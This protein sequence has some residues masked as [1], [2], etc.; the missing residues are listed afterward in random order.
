MLRNPAMKG[1][2]WAAI[3]DVT[4]HPNLDPEHV[5]LTTKMIID[6]PIGPSDKPREEVEEI[7]VGAAREKEIEAKLVNISTDWAVQDLALAHFKTRGE[8]L[9]KGD[10]TAEIQTLL[11]DSLVTLNS[12]A[13]NRFNK[14]FKAQIN[15]WMAALSTVNEVMD[16]WTK[17][18]N[19]WVYLEAVF[20]GGD[21]AKQMPQEA[22]R[23]TNVDKSWVKLMERAR[24]NPG[25]VSCCTVD[26]TLQELLPRM[27]DQLEM[28]QRSLSGYLEGKRRLFPR[29][30]F[31]SDPVLLEILGQ[32]STPEAIQQHLLTIFDSMDHLKFNESVSRVLVAYS[33]DGED[34]PLQPTVECMGP[35]EIWLGQL[36]LCARE[37]LLDRI[38]TSHLMLSDP[39][40]DLLRFF[41]ENP[42]QLGILGIQMIWTHDATEALDEA[43]ENPKLMVDTNRNFLLLLELLISQTTRPLSKY[44]RTKYETLITIHLHQKDIFDSLIKQGIKSSK[45]FEWLKQTRVYYSEDLNVCVVS[46]TN[47]DFVYQNEFLGCTERLVITPLTDRCYI[48]LAQALNMSFGGAPAGPAGTGKTETT[49]DM[50]RCLGQY[51][52]VFNCSD[53]MDFRGLGR[54]FKGLAQSGAWGCFDEFNRIELPVLSVAAQ[55]IAIVLFA[56]RDGQDEFVFSDG[57][58]VPLNA[59]FG[60]FITMNPGYAGRQELPENLKINFR[61]VAMMV[62]DRQI[63]IRVKMASCGF[64][65]NAPLAKKF[66][67]LYGLCE[68]QLSKQVHYDFGLRNILSVLRTFGAVRRSNP[69]EPENRIVMRVLRDMNLSKLVDQDEPLFMSILKDLF[70]GVV[71]TSDVR[72]PELMGSLE[73][74]AAEMDLIPHKPWMLKVLQLYETQNVRHGMMTLGPSGSG[75]SKC[76]NLLLRALTEI[77]EPHKEMRMNPKAITAPQMFGRLDA[78]TN[79]WTDGIFSTLWR[80]TV[81][82]KKGEHCWLILDGPVD[83]IWIE[84]LNSVLDDN[85]TLTLANGDRIPMSPR[86]K[87][88]FEVDNVDNASPATISRN[89]I[90]YISSGALNWE[91]IFKTWVKKRSQ[92]DADKLLNLANHIFPKLI[93]FVMQ[94][95]TVDMRFLEAFYVTQFGRVFDAVVPSLDALPPAGL[96]RIFLFSL[97]WSF[98]ALLDLDG[99][100]R[101]DHFLRTS[102]FKI[103]LPPDRILEAKK[104]IFDFRPDKTLALWEFWGDAVPA[105][106]YP[107]SG[108]VEFEKVLVPN[109]ENVV[110]EYL[111]GSLAKLGR[112]ILLFGEP[113]TAKTAIINKHLSTFHPETQIARIYNFSSVTTPASFQ[114]AMEGFVD[115]RVG[116]TFGP[117]PG[118][119]MTVFLDDISMP[120]VNEWGDQVANEIVRQ[121]MESGGFYSL[122]KPGEFISIVDIQFAAAMGTP[123][124]GR[125]DIPMRLKR[126][127]CVFICNLPGSDSMDHI[128]RTIGLG[129]FSHERGFSDEIREMVRILVPMTRLVWSSVKARMLPTPMKFHYI[130]NLRDLSRIW[131]GMVFACSEVYKDGD[132]LLALWKNEVTRTLA[133][134]LV[135]LKDKD[136]F[137]R[138]LLRI[139]EEEMNP[140][141]VEVCQRK[142]SFCDFMR[143]VF[144]PKVASGVSQPITPHVARV[145]DD[146]FWQ[147]GSSAKLTPHHV[148]LCEGQ[149]EEGKSE[150]ASAAEMNAV[151][152]GLEGG[153]KEANS[154]KQVVSGSE[155]IMEGGLSFQDLYNFMTDMDF[156][157]NEQDD[158]ANHEEDADSEADD[159][160]DDDSDGIPRIYEPVF[161]L[162]TLKARLDGF[163]MQ[164]NEESRGCPL[165]YVFYTKAIGHIIRVCRATRNNRGSVLLVGVGGSGKQSVT[166][167]ATYVS[168]YKLFQINTSSVYTTANL[169]EDLKALYRLAGMSGHGVT[170][171]FVENN[172]KNEIFLDYINNILMGGQVSSYFAREEL[173][174]MGNNL[175]NIYRRKNPRK[176]SELP[177]LIDFFLDRARKNVHLALCFSPIGDKFRSRALAFPGL[178]AGCT[179]DWFHAWP[180]DALV[181]CADFLLETFAPCVGE[182]IL[183]E[184]CVQTIS[185]I[186]MHTQKACEDYFRVMRRTNHVTPKTFFHLINGCK[187]VYDTKVTELREITDRMDSGVRKLVEAKE[188]INVLQVDLVKKEDELIVANQMAEEVLAKVLLETQA[189]ESVKNKVELQKQRCE[190]IVASI[191]A[192]RKVAEAQLEAA[193]P[194]LLEA[195]EALNTIKPADIS[196]VRKLAKPP[197]LIMRI[198]DCVN[199]LFYHRLEPVRPD[200]EKESIM[201]SWKESIRYMSQPNFLANLLDFPKYILTEEMMDLLEHYMSAPDYNIASAKKTCGNVAG[202]LSWTTAMVKFFWVNTVIVPLQD[203]LTKAGQ[204]L[205]RAMKELQNAESILAEK[206]AI[207]KRVQADFDDAMMKKQ[208]LQDE[209]DL[210]RRRMNTAN[211]LIEGLGGEMVR[212]SEQSVTYKQLIIM[213][214]GDAIGLAAFLTYAGGFNQTFRQNLAV[215]TQ[216]AL[217][218]HGVPHSAHLDVVNLLANATTQNE[219][220]VQGLP[221]DELSLE[222]A[223]IA[224]SRLRYPLLV[225]PQ[226]QG[227]KWLSNLYASKFLATSLTHKLFRNHVENALN[228]GLVLFV[229]GIAEEFDPGLDNVLSQSFSRVGNT[230]QVNIWDFE[231]TVDPEFQLF[232]ST[233]LS[234][235]VYSPELLASAALID[236]NVTV[237]GLEDQL[238]AR[239]ITLEREKLERSRVELLTN[240][241]ANKKKVEQLEINLLF[242]LK[243]SQGSLVDDLGLLEVL[244]NTKKTAEAVMIQLA[245]AAETEAEINKAREEYRPVAERGALIYFLIQ[246]MATI[247]IMYESG[248]RQ[249]LKLFDDS[250]LSSEKSPVTQRRIGKIL[251]F[252]LMRLWKF[253]TRGLY[254]K[255]TVMFTLT[256]AIRIGL[257]QNHVRKEEVEVLLKGGSAL[258][259][260]TCPPKPA[261]WIPDNVWLNVNAI[262]KLRSFNGIV[263][264]VMSGERRWRRWYD[265]DAPEEEAFPYGYDSDLSSFGRLILIRAWCT[266]RFV[267]QAKKYISDEL[268]HRFAEDNL[269]NLEEV[270]ADS[271][272]NT[273]IMNLLTVGADP[274]MLIEQFAKRRKI[275]FHF[276]SMGQGQEVHARRFVAEAMKNGGWVLLQNCHLCLDYVLELFNLLAD[277]KEEREPKPSDGTEA[278]E[279]GGLMRTESA[280]STGGG[281]APAT[282]VVGGQRKQEMTVSDKFRLWITTEEHRKFPVNFLQVSIKFTNQP[283][284]GLRSGLAKTYSDIS[285]DFLD[286]CVSIQ[287]KVALYAVAFLHST[288]EGR[289]KFSP[290]GW[291]VPYEFNQADFDASIEFIRSHIDEI[292]F[293]KKNTKT[294]VSCYCC[295][296]VTSNKGMKTGFGIDWKCVRYML[297]EIQYGGR[298]TDS[299]DIII[300]ITLVRRM[301]LEKMFQTGF[302]LAPNYVIPRLSTVNQYLGFI[303]SLPLQESPESVQLHPNAEIEYSTRLSESIITNINSI[304][305][306]DFGGSDASDGSG[307]PTKESQVKQMCQAML[308]RLPPVYNKYEVAERCNA[309][310]SLQPIV[311]FLRQ[312]VQRISKLLEVTRQVLKDLIMGIDGKIIMNAQLREAMEAMYN[313]QVPSEWLRSLLT[314]VRQE[315]SR[316][317]VGWSL[318][319][320]T[321]NTE[322]TK[323]AFDELHDSAKEGI[324]IHGL[325]IQAGSWDRRLGRIVEAKP[326]QLFDIMP[327]I[328]VTAQ[329]SLSQEEINRQQAEKP[330]AT[331]T[332][333]KGDATA[334]GNNQNNNS[335]VVTEQTNMS[336]AVDQRRASAY[337]SG[338]STGTI[339]AKLSVPVYKKVKRTGQHFITKFTI[340]CSKTADHWIM[341]GVALLCDTN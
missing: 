103:N 309:M 128:Y 63:I 296:L 287:W 300:M 16:Y 122:E 250:L 24:E 120:I 59:E 136:W 237:K 80:R 227:K 40:L 210:C 252:M 331:P 112:S 31:V 26:S 185:D 9:L 79:D 127:F 105:Y 131:Q 49:K 45:D 163:L 223:V 17:V 195:E 113:G 166:R 54:I 200:P 43:K 110:T 340:P 220:N 218:N 337:T 126:Q 88:L 11:E 71:L 262:S 23:F 203:N 140:K 244:Q 222:N 239:V 159:D 213:L 151:K 28:C 57:D 146:L 242:R 174:E 7:C 98:G 96:E 149:T 191:S 225:D 243:N 271:S 189:A 64:I 307:G 33:A 238:L 266:D 116:F 229:E 138:N 117:P 147:G 167:L 329:C 173:E 260:Q 53:Q 184:K 99:R 324:F 319:F 89:G 50:G 39:E 281:G 215:A 209:A 312:E 339:A 216:K 175:T 290:I 247:N 196:T 142:A 125:N 123:G 132:L 302:Q 56:K 82:M 47:V 246:D 257:Q 285:Q 156:P 13:N 18:Q 70:P 160:D 277:I 279:T 295:Q 114:A 270:Y 259:I 141:A 6:L 95:L 255:D 91:P 298:I 187:K 336:A 297:S 87:I 84:N 293:A 172:I 106:D 177:Q 60:I 83:A 202:L 182:P 299:E 232:I 165:N 197:N 325:F 102:D 212:W 29:F 208:K 205:N 241:V 332:S 61:T 284:E 78:A 221:L 318:E 282:P 85:K 41:E 14:P 150:P 308:D 233:Q 42:S 219:W 12:L 66:Y 86:C 100:E 121:T 162:P 73:R 201:T 236:F 333:A 335:A 119:R 171:L 207:L 109:Q 310:G 268:G 51:V 118:K 206:T 46:I 254:K 21:I 134:K 188:A 192:D 3:S 235:P 183:R 37:S 263:D 176:P 179:I 273:P 217:K 52:V 245:Q 274:T 161:E 304:T 62:P 35:V 152:E 315:A 338:S 320:V 44:A 130:F 81:K 97:T 267:R 303:N 27:L 180:R 228:N 68:Q 314:A 278:E 19:L 186:H 34:L 32:A 67:Y 305:K 94:E 226:G 144:F 326:K 107:K 158:M 178:I 153:K 5:D 93:K 92:S 317:H 36:L 76:V 275:E 69:D 330:K 231:T 58:V 301:F 170:F 101:F 157:N 133:D 283:P 276:I 272:K 75:K 139:V 74:N 38:R 90:V 164:M 190:K 265:M 115:K 323:Y 291:S 8:L 155:T 269:L 253:F 341:R 169:V 313:A 1:R 230:M 193:K 10:R 198:M 168:G 322:V 327:V 224:T 261:R 181:A 148:T 249:F 108:E 2:H 289:R 211:Q 111:V 240:M 145:S 214:T 124:G 311:I 137:V 258:S 143:R 294:S 234:N 316:Q 104:T 194:A 25:V 199:I 321:L 135:D 292:E 306:S 154:K 256:L 65:E 72:Y 30:F 334:G 248:L 251:K 48:T 328:N 288:V 22:R 204:R 264:Q 129:H 77:D 15:R 55:Q 280:S 286:A 4:N 20:V